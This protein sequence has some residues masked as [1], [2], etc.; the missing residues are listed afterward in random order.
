[1]KKNLRQR[2]IDRK[3]KKPNPFLMSIVMF[4]LGILNRAYK[5]KFS[6]DFDLKSIKKQ[7]YYITNQTKRG[8]ILPLFYHFLMPVPF[9]GLH[10]I[11]S[12][13]LSSASPK[14]V[15]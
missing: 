7:T 13:I 15:I 12:C 3:I 6:Y 9:I 14:L 8:S 11:F 5:V 2:L 1:M 10:F 4:L